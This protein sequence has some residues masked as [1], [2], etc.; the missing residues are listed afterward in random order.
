MG[1]WVDTLWALKRL[2]SWISGD[3]EGLRGVK[4]LGE[5]ALLVVKNDVLVMCGVKSP[6]WRGREV[7]AGQNWEG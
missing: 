4:C 7:S 5:R 3:S 1:F 2:A 6:S